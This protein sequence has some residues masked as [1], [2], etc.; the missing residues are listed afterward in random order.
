M[1]VRRLR[2]ARDQEPIAIT[3]ASQLG[4]T[5]RTSR[6]KPIDMPSRPRIETARPHRRLPNHRVDATSTG[7]QGQIQTSQPPQDYLQRTPDGTI[8]AEV[9]DLLYAAQDNALR[10]DFETAGRTHRPAHAGR[11]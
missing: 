6:P 2:R 7:A 9:L 8:I 3:D 4:Y 11:L 1:L 5:P 10:K